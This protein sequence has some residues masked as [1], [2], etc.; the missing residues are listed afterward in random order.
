MSC[1]GGKDNCAMYDSVVKAYV[2]YKFDAIVGGARVAVLDSVRALN[3]DVEACQKTSLT[4]VPRNAPR[5]F[6]RA[7]TAMSVHPGR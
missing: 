3:L 4:A 2:L 5:Y 6:E 7:A 1:L